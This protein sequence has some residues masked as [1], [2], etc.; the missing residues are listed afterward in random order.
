MANPGQAAARAAI[1]AWFAPANVPGLSTIY[2]AMPKLEAG[3][4]FDL[5][6]GAGSGAVMVVHL[7][8]AHEN[9]IA[10]GGLTSGEKFA[11][12]DLALQVFFRSVKTDAMVAQDDQDALIDV[13]YAR[14]RADRTFG[15]TPASYNGSNATIWQAGEGSAGIEYQQ[16]EMVMSGQVIC[17]DAVIRGEVW[18]YIAA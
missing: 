11:K 10:M 13:V 3:H 6:A 8:G 2:R 4:D 1:A 12:Y 7:T 14:W 16:T 5:A 9:R 17:I 15:T 18:L